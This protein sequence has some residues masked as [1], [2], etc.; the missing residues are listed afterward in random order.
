MHS[1]PF[2]SVPIYRPKKEGDVPSK[3]FGKSA[4]GSS[5]RV[6]THYVPASNSAA[7][8][9]ISSPGTFCSN[10]NLQKA[11]HPVI[12]DSDSDEDFPVAKMA[13]SNKQSPGPS[14]RKVSVPQS[15]T[16]GYGKRA[17]A[18]WGAGVKVYSDKASS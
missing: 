10:S 7:Y 18:Q 6:S 12:I 1:K 17:R 13:A 14:K 8:T 2:I 9:G 4:S 5:G 3:Y 16:A 15:L 11:S